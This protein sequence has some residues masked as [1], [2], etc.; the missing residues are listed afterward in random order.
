MESL[1]FQNETRVVRHFQFLT[2]PD[3]SRPKQSVT[4]IDF[5]RKVTSLADDSLAAVVVHC[6]QVISDLRLGRGLRVCVC[7]C[8]GEGGGISL[9]K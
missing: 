5:I 8:G 1:P 7:V 3:K 9:L 2:W 4:L 6:R